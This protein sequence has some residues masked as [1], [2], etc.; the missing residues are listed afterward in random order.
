[1]TK[2]LGKKQWKIC[3]K[4]TFNNIYRTINDWYIR[5]YSCNYLYIYGKCV[6]VY[7]CWMS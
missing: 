7:M 3:D 4:P 2:T 1:M 6:Y 5:I